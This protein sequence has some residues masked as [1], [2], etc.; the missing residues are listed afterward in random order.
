[1]KAP[2]L[3]TLETELRAGCSSRR[4]PLTFLFFAAQNN[5]TEEYVMLITCLMHP[6][7]WI[8]RFT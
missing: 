7:M 2:T 4:P 5:L 6:R 8:L 1:M 3:K